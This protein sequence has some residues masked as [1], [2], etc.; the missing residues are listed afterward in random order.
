[1]TSEPVS[2][3]AEPRA[4]DY[5]GRGVLLS[6][7]NYL[8]WL[9]GQKKTAA[10]AGETVPLPPPWKPGQHWALVGKTR[11][12]KTNFAV[13]MLTECRKYVL[14]LDPKG[15]DETLTASGWERVTGVPPYKAFPRDIQKR[16]DEGTEP[17]RLIVGLDSRTAESDE[18]NKRLMSQAVEYVRQSR[19]W[20]MYTDEHQILTDPRMFRVGPQVARAAVS[21][22]SAKTSV[23][24]TMQY[25]SWSE[26]APLRQ[27]SMWSIWKTRNRNL[28]K[29][30]ADEIGRDWQELG[31]IL[32]ELRKYD[33]LTI[34]DE[35]RAPL[36][37]TRP[38]K[39]GGKSSTLWD[40]LTTSGA[41]AWNPSCARSGT[42][43]TAG[44][45]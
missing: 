17:V 43:S 42:G 18:A 6:W 23:V 10:L 11:E 40:C 27:A 16:L 37:V 34:S 28:V 24:S 25:I 4:G 31:A 5:G 44:I 21:A 30:L 12:G 8:A 2:R 35:L 3:A 26:K 7:S 33:M 41:P 39:I 20:T 32:D 36:I 29:A 38:P 9:R 13:V 19:G 1:M 15:E 14:A 22:A 45:R